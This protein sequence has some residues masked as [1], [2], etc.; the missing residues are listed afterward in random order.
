MQT[1]RVIGRDYFFSLAPPFKRTV[2]VCGLI[3]DYVAP[4]LVYYLQ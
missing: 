2:R 1:L 3:T 4:L